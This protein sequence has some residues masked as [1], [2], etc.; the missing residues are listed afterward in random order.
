MIRQQI[1]THLRVVCVASCLDLVSPHCG[2][3]A[4]KAVLALPPIGAEGPELGDFERL[5]D[6]RVRALMVVASV[7]ICILG[8]PVVEAWYTS[9]KG[10]N[11]THQ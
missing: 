5:Y 4:V 10:P 3:L 11:P 6:L 1:E 2:L 9:H 8:R 7:S